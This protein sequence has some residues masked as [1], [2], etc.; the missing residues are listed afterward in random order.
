M[1]QHLDRWYKQNPRLKIK[2][3][4]KELAKKSNNGARQTCTSLWR[5]GLSGVHLTLSGAQAGAPDGQAALE[6]T[7]RSRLKFIELSDEPR[8]NGHLRQRSTA[9]TTATVRSPEAVNDVRSHQTVRW[10][11]RADESNGRLQRATD[12]AGTGHWTVSCPVCPSIESYCFL[13]NVYMRG[14]GL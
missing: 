4:P 8:V 14:W 6:K 13:F 12:V 3:S 1:M 7:H 11:I 10:A 5:T 2:R 9:T